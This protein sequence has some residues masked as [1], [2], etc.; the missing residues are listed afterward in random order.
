VTGSCSRKGRWDDP[1]SSFL[2]NRP[3]DLKGRPIVAIKFVPDMGAPVAVTAVDLLLEQFAPDY[4]KWATG[5]MAVGGY[6]G[7]YLNFGGD[8]VKNVGIASLPAFAKNLYD[9]ATSGA[10]ATRAASRNLSFRR[11]S[12]WPAPAT[13]TE[14][15]GTKITGRGLI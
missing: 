2:G 12:R 4:S 9:W 14:F 11:A 8:F 7:A 10:S 5:I 13:E 15:T 3:Q 6:V 1:V